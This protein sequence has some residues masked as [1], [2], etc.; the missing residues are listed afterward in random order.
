MMNIYHFL[1]QEYHWFGSDGEI[2]CHRS[3]ADTYIMMR[4]GG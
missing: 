4:I 1:R 3:S 2:I